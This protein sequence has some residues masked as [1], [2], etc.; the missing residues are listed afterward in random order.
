MYQDELFEVKASL[1]KQGYEQTECLEAA[2][3]NGEVGTIDM[4][5]AKAATDHGTQLIYL[6]PGLKVE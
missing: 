5:K 4:V 1:A 6:I 2:W 3:R